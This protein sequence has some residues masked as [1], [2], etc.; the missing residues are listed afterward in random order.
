MSPQGVFRVMLRMQIKPDVEADFERVW[1]EI[2]DSITSHPANLGQWLFRNVEEP[3]IYYIVS[4]WVDES[5]FREFE[6][7]DRHVVHRQKLHP[8][9]SGSSMAIMQT[10]AHL[11][12]LATAATHQDWEAAR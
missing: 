6:K 10:V 5:R 8:F 1:L 4:D 2:G 11:P 12:S 3:A 7:S 9:R